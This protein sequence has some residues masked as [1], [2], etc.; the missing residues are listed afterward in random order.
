M[1]QEVIV[2]LGM[3]RSGTSAVTRGLK[4]LGMELGDHLVPAGEDN[5]RGFWENSDIVALNTRVLAALGLTW[6]SLFLIPDSRWRDAA[7]LELQSRAAETVRNYAE[8]L[9]PWGF[10][11]PRTLRVLPFW[12]GVFGRL[13][14]TP[15][16][17]LVVRNPLSVAQSLFRR[18]RFDPAKSC[19]LWSLHLVPYLTQIRGQLRAVIDYDLLLNNPVE[20]LG[21]IAAPLG[22]AETVQVRA[23]MEKYARTFLTH[24]LRHSR[25]TPEHAQN[26]PCLDEVG[27][28]AYQWLLRLARDEMG[29]EAAEFWEVWSEL[30]RRLLAEMPSASPGPPPDGCQ[31]LFRGSVPASSGPLAY[32]AG[33]APGGVTPGVVFRRRK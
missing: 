18:D 7:V 14:L 17:L 3:H 25:Y 27:R 22:M 21:R 19:R 1:A 12:I 16:Y 32:A 26:D 15:R 11:D 33:H 13:A 6:D 5:P 2:V 24:N 8:S 20:Q 10:K 9:R 31:L 4:A 28:T 29:P 23:E 30:E